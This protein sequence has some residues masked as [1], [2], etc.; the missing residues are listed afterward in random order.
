M[1]K[2]RHK[3]NRRERSAAE[4]ADYA[5]PDDGVLTLRCGLSGGTIQKLQRAESN[6]AASVDDLWRRRMEMLFEHL[7]VSWTIAGMP[8]TGQKMLL[9]R[10]RMASADEQRW[11]R[12]TIEAHVAAHIPELAR[13]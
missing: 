7:A 6:P 9:G 13:P 2:K 1:A 4:T 12:E 10:Y 11:V 3:G 5:G 8:I